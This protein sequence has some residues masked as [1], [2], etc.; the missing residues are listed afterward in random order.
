MPVSVLT[1]FIAEEGGQDLLEYALLTAAIGMSAVVAFNL[2]SGAINTTYSSW[3]TSVNCLW[4]P[5]TKC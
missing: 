5:A 2:W 3:N 1:R 4:D